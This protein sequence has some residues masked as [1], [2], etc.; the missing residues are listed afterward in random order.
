[1]LISKTVMIKWT[2]NVSTHYKNLGYKFTKVN[3]YFEAKIEDVHS[4]SQVMVDVQCDYCGRYYSKKYQKYNLHRRV[5]AKDCCK[6]CQQLKTKEC[7]MI[8]FGVIH[9]G[10]LEPVKEKRKQTNLERFGVDHPC[11]N[12]EIQNKIKQTNLERRGVEYTFQSEE[13]QNKS[14]E[15]CLE[16][17]GVEN[18][19]QLE[20]MQEKIKELIFNLYGV[21]NVS[22]S[23]EI[24]KKIKESLYNNKTGV[25]S[26]CQRYICQLLNGELNYPFK[27]YSLDIAFPEKKIYIEY[28]GSGHNLSVFKGEISESK[29][30]QKQVYRRYQLYNENWNEIR[31][32][33]KY[34]KLPNDDMIFEM[35]NYAKMYFLTGHSWILFD[36]DNSYVECSQ[37]KNEYDYGKIKQLPR[38]LI[39]S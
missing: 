13:V 4:N 14:K 3:D 17:Y 22:K 30:K 31:I 16:R 19:F 27:V 9:P 39:V 33:S 12:E 20:E 26:K 37:F 18:V 24:M 15:T 38:D 35:F 1:M 7:N 11:K 25:S 32:I 6:K 5:V 10:Q 21:D 34:D 8:N 36:I 28:D 2:R 23:P 29:F